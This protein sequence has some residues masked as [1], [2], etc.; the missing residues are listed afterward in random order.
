[1]A[2]C[3][4][5]PLLSSAQEPVS[6][7]VYSCDLSDF[8][9]IQ[10]TIIY[11]I[12]LSIH[13]LKKLNVFLKEKNPSWMKVFPAPFAAWISC[14]LRAALQDVSRRGQTKLQLGVSRT[15]SRQCHHWVKMG[16]ALFCGFRASNIRAGDRK[17]KRVKS[18]EILPSLWR[19]QPCEMRE[20]PPSPSPCQGE[21]GDCLS[22]PKVERRLQGGPEGGTWVQEQGWLQVTGAGALGRDRDFPCKMHS[23]RQRGNLIPG[24]ESEEQETPEGP[25]E[26]S[27]A[28]GMREER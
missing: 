24:R 25:P 12:F 21:R 3:L 26:G 15:G 13:I 5:R 11:T 4:R 17:G 6:Q 23:N 22:R 20:P 9:Y 14:I 19:P 2:D 16:E 1:M 7:T 28:G 27:K 18:P 10:S 8:L